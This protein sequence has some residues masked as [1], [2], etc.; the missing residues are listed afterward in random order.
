MAGQNAY[1]ATVKPIKGAVNQ[2]SGKANPTTKAVKGSVAI[3]PKGA[4][5]LK[6][7]K[8]GIGVGNSGQY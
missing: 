8:G 3:A 7:I 6:S 4:P 2:P 5:G 1:K